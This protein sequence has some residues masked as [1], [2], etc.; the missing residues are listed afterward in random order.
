L[1]FQRAILEILDAAPARNLLTGIARYPAGERLLNAMS[2]S[3]GAYSSFAEAWAVARSANAVGHEDPNTVS[4]HFRL[5]ETLRPSDYAALYWIAKIQRDGAKIF[6]Y[7]GNAGNLYYSYAPHLKSASGIH[8]VV[9]D[10]PIVTEKGMRI[11]AERGATELTFAGG[12][13]EFRE[14]QILLISGAFHYWENDIPALLRQFQERPRHII[15]NRSPVHETQ[16]SFIAVQRTASLAVPCRVWNAKE[17]IG[18]FENEGYELVDRW[19]AMELALKLPLFPERWV[20]HYS[21]FY[22]TRA[23]EQS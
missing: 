5:S 9:Y 1:S 23:A 21:G 19:K 3:Y 17:L 11:A 10:I 7:G 6:D 22:F 16:P 15:I 14:E 13:D 12:V 4:S 18:G 8:W 2:G 20:T